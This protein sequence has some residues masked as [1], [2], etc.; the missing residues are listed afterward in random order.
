MLGW[1]AGAFFR[2]L[3]PCRTS[4]R[5]E[6]SWGEIENPISNRSCYLETCYRL[7]W[8]SGSILVMIHMVSSYG[9]VHHWSHASALESTAIESEQVTGIR[10]PW[11]VYVN[12]AFAAVWFAYSLAMCIC[13][14]RIRV[15]DTIVFW[16]TLLIVLSATVI[17]EVGWVRW[18]SLAGFSTLAILLATRTSREA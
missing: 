16:S 18:L 12:F 13:G 10:A 17:F 9:L 11:G 5:E 14:R 2:Q 8:L 7:A 3:S 1:F 6:G 4:D 15:L